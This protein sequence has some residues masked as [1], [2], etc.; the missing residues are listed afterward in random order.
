MRIRDSS[1]ATNVNSPSFVALQYAF[2]ET[3]REELLI[4]QGN[5]LSVLYY[6]F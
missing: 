3:I 6:L 4:E 1:N 5:N 2:K